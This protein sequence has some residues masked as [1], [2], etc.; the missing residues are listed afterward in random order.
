AY[1]GPSIQA[2]S[3]L[4]KDRAEEQ[5]TDL[6]DEC[7]TKNPETGLFHFDFPKFVT[8]QLVELGFAEKNIRKSEVDTG[9]DHQYFSFTRHKSD[10]ENIPDGRNGF[11]VRQLS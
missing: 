8:K 10:P 9:A 6:W 2:K 4:G 11:V 5:K 3:Y 7:I 1:L